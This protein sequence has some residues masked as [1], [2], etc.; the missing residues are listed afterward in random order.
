MLMIDTLPDDDELIYTFETYYESVYPG[1]HR[2]ILAWAT[3]KRPGLSFNK[4]IGV[5][6]SRVCAD[7]VCIPQHLREALARL[8]LYKLIEYDQFN[9]ALR[10]Q[11]KRT[12]R[13]V[14][15]QEAGQLLSS[16]TVIQKMTDNDGRTHYLFNSTIGTQNAYTLWSEQVFMGQLRLIT[17]SVDIDDEKYTYESATTDLRLYEDW[18]MAVDSGSI[19]DD[20]YLRTQLNTEQCVQPICAPRDVIGAVQNAFTKNPELR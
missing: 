5:R 11:N 12:A 6:Q 20:A 13:M 8:G 16:L 2:G 18:A 1:K 17:K 9:K 10:D 19:A 14:N 7:G 15:V 4:V 3:L